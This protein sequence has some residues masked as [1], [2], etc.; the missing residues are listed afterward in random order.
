MVLAFWKVFSHLHFNKF[1][2]QQTDNDTL[3][4]YVPLCPM[5]L[6]STSS[7]PA[8]SSAIAQIIQ[9]L[10]FSFLPFLTQGL[11]WAVFNKIWN[12]LFLKNLLN[13]NQSGFRSGHFTETALLMVMESLQAGK[14]A[15][16]SSILIL[17]DLSVSFDTVK[18]QILLSALPEVGMFGSALDWLRSFLSRQNSKVFW[19]GK[20]SSSHGLFAGLLQGFLLGHPRFSFYTTSLGSTSTSNTFSNHYFQCFWHSLIS[21]PPCFLV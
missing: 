5:L 9:Q 8:L 17:L 15:A 18:H 12:I 21:L 7:V 3:N 10:Q 11:K 4:V 2:M 20:I 13:I 19:L 14:A 6:C 16:Q 1:P